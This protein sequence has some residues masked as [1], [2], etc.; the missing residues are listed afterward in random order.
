MNTKSVRTQYI[1]VI[2][3]FIGLVMLA[4]LPGH[5]VNAK[6][7]SGFVKVSPTNG[8]T[9]QPLTL[10]LKWSSA[11]SNPY[12]FAQYYKYC[13]YK[14][15][16][17]CSY[18]GTIY[19]TEYTISNLSS[20]TTYYW[21]IQVVYCKDSSCTQKE[22][23]EANNGQVWSF[24][25]TGANPPGSFAKLSPA[26]NAVNINTRTLIW[27]SSQNATSY[28]YCIS[29][30][31][32]DNDCVYLGG[33]KD[34]GNVTSYTIP[35]DAKFIWG[36]RYYWQIRASSGG[37]TRLANDGT[38]WSFTTAD[39]VGRAT[40]ISPTGIITSSTP[41]YRWNHISGVTWYYLQV[42]GPTGTVIREWF[43]AAVI[44]SG[45]TCTTTPSVTL[46]PGSFTWWVQTWS[47]VGYGPWS[48]G[49]TF[50]TPVPTIPGAAILISPSGDIGNNYSPTFRWN[51]V[52][53]EVGSHEESA[54]TWYYL[55]INGPSGNIFAQWYASSSICSGGTC[56]VTPAITL[57][58]GNH[59]WW[60]QTWNSVGYG[61]WSAGMNFSTVVPP[62]PGK[63]TLVSPAG[64]ITNNN[65]TYT[66]NQVSGAS[67]Y[68]LW[69]DGPSGH[70][71]HQWYTSAQAN[72]NGTTCSVANVTSGLGAGSYTWWV[73]TWNITGYG[74]WSDGK[75]FTPIP[76]GKATLVSPNGSLAGGN[77]TYTWN[78]VSGATW[79][80]LWVD[81]SNGNVFQKWYTS[82]Q[83]NCN[84]TT[85][86]VANATP[87]LSGGSYS[88]WIQTWN[89]A[90]YGPWSDGLNFSFP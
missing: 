22:K 84:G 38:W 34:V 13:Y 5:I 27:A 76:P 87:N 60:V 4:T 58:G 86:S 68:Y 77:P 55:W 12:H 74:P 88:W 81:G 56:S 47:N 9:N 89:D 54:A 26:N 65:P 15:N 83:A 59:T 28:Q 67:W 53:S 8:A 72:C 41:A 52:L 17:T 42:N 49:L 71:F 6:A 18:T 32:N 69:V 73:Q 85:C 11:P 19:A 78:Q 64:N 80:F 3:L 48:N 75:T 35:N 24:Q 43:D 57:G 25:T 39:L 1:P 10:T 50:N 7:L 14:A 51:E 70:V 30:T 79:Y 29:T 62:L 20:G 61:P 36:E 16:G 90:G 2:S 31:Y 46:G 37:G 63:A 44:C 45:G 82:A 40:L 21:Q 33:W 23:H 66:W